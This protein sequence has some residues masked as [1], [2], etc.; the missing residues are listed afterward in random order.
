MWC[1]AMPIS[2]FHNSKLLNLMMFTCPL[3]ISFFLQA[4]YDR[5]GVWMTYTKRVMYWCQYRVPFVWCIVTLSPRVQIVLSLIQISIIRIFY[6]SDFNGMLSLSI[7]GCLT[8]KGDIIHVCIFWVLLILFYG[9]NF[10]YCLV[11]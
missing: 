8:W 1:D 4:T 3:G 7:R 9:W 5:V 2:R 6:T 10:N 11:E